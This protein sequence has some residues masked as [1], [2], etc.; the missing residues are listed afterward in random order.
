MIA[1]KDF[2]EWLENKAPMLPL[3]NWGPSHTKIAVLFASYMAARAARSVLDE[4]LNSGD[5][6]YRP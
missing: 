6:S 1:D 5:G 3:V 2:D 4:A